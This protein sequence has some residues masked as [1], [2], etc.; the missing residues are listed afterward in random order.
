MADPGVPEVATGVERVPGSVC[1]GL[2][3]SEKWANSELI[4]L[5]FGADNRL[6]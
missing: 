5:R 6:R 4:R 3:T 2:A 1:P